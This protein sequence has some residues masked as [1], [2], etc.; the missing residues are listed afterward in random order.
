[1]KI[2]VVARQVG[3]YAGGESHAVHAMKRQGVG[4]DLHRARA[5]A[6]IP[7]FAQEALYLGRFRRRV[8]RL[9]DLLANAVAH[10]SEHPAPDVRRFKNRRHEERRGGFS[11]GAGDANDLHIAARMPVKGVG[12]DRQSAARV[13]HDD[14]RPVRP[15]WRRL[16]RYDADGTAFDRLARVRGTVGMKAFERN[17]Q[18]TAFGPARVVRDRRDDRFGSV[19]T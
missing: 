11:V 14:P 16:F 12:E 2:E 18:V 17:E 1:V 19:R 10:R 5:A 9:A 8:C 3:E 4:G 13:R 6:A 15:G 7:H